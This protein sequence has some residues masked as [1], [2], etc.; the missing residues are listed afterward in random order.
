MDKMHGFLKSHFSA[1]HTWQQVCLFGRRLKPEFLPIVWTVI[2]LKLFLCEN[3]G[4][5]TQTGCLSQLFLSLLLNYFL[6]NKVDPNSPYLSINIWKIWLTGYDYIVFEEKGIVHLWI[7]WEIC[8]KN[9]SCF[10]LY[11][12]EFGLHTNLRY[13]HH[14]LLCRFFWVQVSWSTLFG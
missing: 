6:K 9:Q 5:H 13:E 2:N 12:V 3:A 14:D 10:T 1:H 8:T 11:L 4:E 7:A